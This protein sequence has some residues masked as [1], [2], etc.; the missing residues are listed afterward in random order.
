MFFDYFTNKKRTMISEADALKGRD[1][2]AYDVPHTHTVLGTPIQEE[3]PEKMKEILLGMGC[4]WGAERLFWKLD[5]VVSTAVGYA[6]GFTQQS[7]TIG[8]AHALGISVHTVR[9]YTKSLFRKLG[10]HS[11]AEAAR[12]AAELGVA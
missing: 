9:S 1:A 4:F 3:P 2:Y 12:R 10:V 5:G 7:C 6:G 11:R 8:A